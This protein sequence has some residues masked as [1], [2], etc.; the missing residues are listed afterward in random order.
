MIVEDHIL[1]N[2]DSVVN[3]NQDNHP[4]EVLEDND[5]ILAAHNLNVVVVKE[6]LLV[7]ELHSVVHLQDH[8]KHCLEEEQ[9]QLEDH[10]YSHNLAASIA[11]DCNSDLSIL[12]KFV[13]ASYLNM[14]VPVVEL[15]DTIAVV[16]VVVVEVA[17]SV[18][19]CTP[20]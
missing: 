11:V 9:G 20:G 13:V 3:H 17:A 4:F 10:N 1:D 8:H 6:L 2:F 12:N 14:V 7:V 18:V 15:E 5:H 16:V 19:Q